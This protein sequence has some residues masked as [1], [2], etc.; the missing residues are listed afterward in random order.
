MT[1]GGNTMNITI[2]TIEKSYGDIKA[3]DGPSFDIPSGSTFG[4]LGTNGAGKTTLFRLLVGHDTPDS[5]TISIG[6]MNTE[7]AG[8]AVRH[9]I[10]YLP[11]QVGFPGLLTGTEVLELHAQIHQLTP[12]ATRIEKA[13]E[14]VGL[15]DA[16]DRTIEGY[17]NG[18]RRRLGLAAAILAEPAVLVLDE[19]TAGL[20]PRGVESFHRIIER[21]NQETDATVVLTSHVLSEVE[22][23]CDRI[24]ILHEGQLCA[25]GTV[26]DLTAANSAQ[27][28][29]ELSPLNEVT[30]RNLTSKL[31]SQYECSVTDGAIRITCPPTTIPA[32]LEAIPDGMVRSIDID[33]PGLTAVFHAVIENEQAVNHS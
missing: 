26:D 6:G 15:T 27:A 1:T 19:P 33:K 4:V 5:G 17:S 10:G 23:V 12:A 24:A 30:K 13:L 32:V 18:M 14:R 22:R 7:T 28:I 9:H 20:D 3:L 16:G 31:D 8:D 25:V 21:I 2:E 29:I 11:E